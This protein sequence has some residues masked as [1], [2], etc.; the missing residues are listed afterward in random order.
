MSL[1]QNKRIAR[2]FLAASAAHDGDRFESLLTDAATYWVQGKRHLYP[3]SGE[4]TRAEI[5]QYMRTPSIFKDGL[6]QT[7]GAMTAEENRVAVEVEVT[8]KAP[9][10]KIY[11][12][13]FHYLLMFRD[14]KIERVKE[15]VDT[16]HAAEIFV[17]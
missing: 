7:I 8:G 17:A 9:N 12:N 15:Y 1:E 11:N 6:T 5:C 2:E 10:G 3:Y 16:Y 14:G 4:R 13:T